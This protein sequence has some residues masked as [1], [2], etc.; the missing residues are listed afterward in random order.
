[1]SE[2]IDPD[3]N[4]SQWEN[5]LADA[6]IKSVPIDYLKTIVIKMM[7]GTEEVFD[8]Q[9]LKNRNL[10]TSEIEKLIEA[11]VDQF[12]EDIDTL[13]FVLNIET[14]ASEVGTKTKRLLGD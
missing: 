7:D 13:D 14:I 11:F 5:I 4:M 6:D 10:T 3:D 1:M 2:N 8:V 12:D 9:N